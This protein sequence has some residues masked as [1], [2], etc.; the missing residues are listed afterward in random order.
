[1]DSFDIDAFINQ[2]F[3]N[4]E[5]KEKLKNK[6]KKNEPE[7]L[8]STIQTN[9]EIHKFPANNNTATE[10]NKMIIDDLSQD[11]IEEYNNNKINLK[12]YNKSFFEETK[13]TKNIPI[14][15]FIKPMFPNDEVFEKEF[16]SDKAYIIDKFIK[17]ENKKNK[18]KQ[19]KLNYTHGL[20]KQLKNENFEYGNLLTMN[21]MWQEYITELMNNTNNEENILSKVLKADLHGAI[22]TVVKSTNIN[23]I[24]IEGIVLFESKRTF[25]ILNKKNEIKTVL[26]QGSVFEI[27]MDYIKAKIILYGD[28]FIFK[29][30]ERTKIK[31]KPK[32]YFNLDIFN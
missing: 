26:K 12:I 20:V 28:N 24:G 25:N 3:K 15:D 29:S 18:K 30:T 16:T 8:K 2:S 4:L 7:T 6:K 13:N 5:D 21:K 14:K 22:L 19:K 31:F 1:M 27:F 11:K 9:N 32:Y 10:K 17:T 23:N